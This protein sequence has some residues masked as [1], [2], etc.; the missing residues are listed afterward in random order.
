MININYKNEKTHNDKWLVEKVFNKAR[1]GFYVEAGAGRGYDDSCTYVLEKHFGWAGILVEPCSTAFSYLQKNRPNSFCINKGLS[2]S[3]QVLDYFSFDGFAGY[4]GFPSISKLGEEKWWEKINKSIN[5]APM[6]KQSVECITL[7]EAIKR[8][9][10]PPIIDCLCLDT[11]GAELEI[12]K[13]FPFDKYIFKA[14]TIEYSTPE[15]TE[16]L[17]KNKYIQTENPYCEV[18]WEH[19]FIHKDFEYLIKDV[20]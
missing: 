14:I 1:N 16:L 4:N 5:G 15:L 17:L 3:C 19:Y 9:N 12:L 8:G 2:S 18:P 11:E 10:A 6:K 7:Y 20:K 13:E